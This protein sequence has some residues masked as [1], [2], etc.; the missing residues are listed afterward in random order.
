M[1]HALIIDDNLIISRAIRSRL[2]AFGFDSFDHTWAEQ[3]AIDAAAA[4][5][6]DLIVVGDTMS[7]GSP[8]EVADKLAR[9][10]DAPVLMVTTDRFMLRNRLPKCS[11]VDGPH[12]LSELDA[13]LG[14][15]MVHG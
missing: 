5:T 2:E 4:R 3:Q 7:K 12:A 8:I 13:A 9:S 11:V 10:N 14:S 6:P 15:I 1:S